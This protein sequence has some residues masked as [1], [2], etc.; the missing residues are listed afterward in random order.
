MTFPRT[1]RRVVTP[2]QIVKST[3]ASPQGVCDCISRHSSLRALFSTSLKRDDTLVFR[4]GIFAQRK[5][6]SQQ[7]GDESAKSHVVQ[8]P[9]TTLVVEDLGQSRITQVDV[10]S[11]PDKASGRR[12]RYAHLMKPVLAARQADVSTSIA[13]TQ[14]HA[15][16]PEV[17]STSSTFEAQNTLASFQVPVV[18]KDN[19]MPISRQSQL[20]QR[21]WAARREQV[22]GAIQE[23]QDALVA[24]LSR[25]RL[26]S[27]TPSKSD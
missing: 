15:T 8:E 25:Q 18:E 16:S 22:L 19:A 5:P 21:M 9:G 3:V 23:E 27:C 6:A 2:Y 20:A 26:Q 17:S 13:R 12:S 1:A 14:E 4:Y 10:T 24:I 7:A 11:T